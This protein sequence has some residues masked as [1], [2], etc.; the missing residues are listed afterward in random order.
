MLLLSSECPRSP[1]RR[2]N[3]LLTKILGVI[4]RTTYSIRCTAGISPNLRERQTENSSIREESIIRNFDWMCFDRGE[5]LEGRHSD[6]WYWRIGKLDAS[7]IHSR[8]LNAKE[9]LKK[10]T[11]R[12]ICISCGRW[13][14]IIIR[15]GLRSPRI[16]PEAAMDRKEGEL[17]RRI[18]QW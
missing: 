4:Q 7:D 10:P 18:S 5:N 6:C 3:S 12:R 13:Y 8:R 9:I 14:G 17:Q 11:R 15:K 1:D 16:H 2:E